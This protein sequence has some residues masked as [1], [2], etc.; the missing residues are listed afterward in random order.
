MNGSIEIGVLTS[1]DL[2]LLS[3]IYEWGIAVIKGI[4]SIESPLLTTVMKF[5]TAMGTELLYI[6]LVFLFFWCIDEKQGLRFSILILFSVWINGFFKVLLKQPRPYHL[7]PTVMRL[8]ESGY[9]I[10]SGHTQHSLVF[11]AAFNR[12]ARR[13]RFRIPAAIISVFFIL[14]V[15]F[16]RLYLGVHFPT[17][18]AAGW[19][20]GLIIL[21]IYFTLGDRLASL[22]AARGTR[23]Q[24]IAAAVSALLM[25][26]S[27][28]DRNLGG[29]FLGICGGY[30]LMRKHIR[31]S[32]REPVRGRRPGFAILAARYALGLIGAALIYFGLRLI[33]PGETSFLA[34][35]DIW[36]AASPYYELGRF[37]QYGVLGLWASAGAP[38]LFRHLGLAGGAEAA[39]AQAE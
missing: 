21:A 30:S 12:L 37:V 36:G 8:A 13:N 22:L 15:P 7:D 39:S 4:Q 9:G 32:A 19:L 25:N 24:L 31:F 2:P 26:A 34:D 38:W 1:G 10:P 23:F 3:L 5:L 11:W 18:I 17:D 33:L 28:A 14:A 29:L 27:G 35:R 16:T 20:L 6:P